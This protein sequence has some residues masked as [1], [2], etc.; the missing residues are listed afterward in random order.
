LATNEPILFFLLF[1]LPLE[2]PIPSLSLASMHVG[3]HQ[4][5]TSPAPLW[6]TVVRLM[7]PTYAADFHMFSGEVNKW[8]H[9]VAGWI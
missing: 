7:Q 8:A 3:I 1:L 2:S 5:G 4:G 6:P 9:M